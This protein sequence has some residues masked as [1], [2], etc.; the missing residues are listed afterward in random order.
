MRW[1]TSRRPAYQSWI[2][3]THVC[4]HW[5]KLA[6]DCGPLWTNITLRNKGAGEFLMR[7]KA[8]PLLVNIHS[9][10]QEKLPFVKEVLREFPR[11]RKLSLNTSVSAWE[12]LAPYFNNVAPILEDLSLS[13]DTNGRGDEPRMIT[14]NECTADVIRESSRLR[15]LVLEH[16]SLNP[17]SPLLSTHMSSL[18]IT[19]PPVQYPTTD[20]LSSLLHMPDLQALTLG[21]AFTR[22][23][24]LRLDQNVPL[25]RL[26]KLTLE[27]VSFEEELFFLS[28]LRFG[29]RVDVSLTSYVTDQ[30]ANPF[31]RFIQALRECRNTSAQQNCNEISLKYSPDGVSLKILADG[32][33]K[34]LLKLSNLDFLQENIERWAMAL[35]Q[36]PLSQLRIF[37]TDYPMHQD[38]W[39]NVM[40]N[41]RELRI[42]QVYGADTASGFFQYLLENYDVTCPEEVI[43]QVESEIVAAPQSAVPPGPTP[44]TVNGTA[45]AATAPTGTENT[46]VVVN[47]ASGNTVTSNSEPPT[48]PVPWPEMFM[49]R[50]ESVLLEDVS[51]E[52][53]IPLSQLKKL[54]LARAKC[55]SRLSN[56]QLFNCTDLPEGLDGLKQVVPVV[57][58]GEDMWGPTDFE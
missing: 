6:L 22:G 20:W 42:V 17:L 49:P 2:V 58:Y 19:N 9:Y 26:N 51:F 55:G 36:L 32:G 24:Q 50:L 39:H 29:N 18:T 27:G 31:G 47:A 45:G 56:L 8:S 4:R 53:F 23:P 54:L 12:E 10:S 21:G 13:F 1:F 5:R 35:A 41:P 11:I 30:S 14:N 7:S 40:S 46:L 15:A 33:P 44:A 34:I 43:N 16:C 57:W 28:H 37:R 52:E 38:F 3:V 48:P 25:P